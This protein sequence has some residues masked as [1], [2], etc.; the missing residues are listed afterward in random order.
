MT[1]TG[2]RLTAGS[3]SARIDRLPATRADMDDPL[4][5]SASAC[6]S[7]STTCCSPAYVAPSLVKSGVLTARDPGPVR[8][9][10]RRELHRRLVCRP[11]RRNPS[12]RLSRRPLRPP[13]DLH[14][15]AALVL[16]GQ[17]HGGATD[18]R[19]RPQP[20][21]VRLR[22]RAGPRDGD[23]RRLRQRAGAEGPSGTGLRGQPGDRLYLRAGDLV[24]RLRTGSRR[25][26]SESRAGAGS[27]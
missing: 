4:S 7:S 24:P 20:L 12:V 26:R 9:D 18:G 13:G 8:H 27:C 3:I 6:S 2:S 10:R 5:S 21:A 22:R 16:G 23:D 25:R 14:L 11:F 15:V 19:F 17:C 1:D